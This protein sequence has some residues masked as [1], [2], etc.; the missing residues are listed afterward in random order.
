[1]T[2]NPH[3]HDGIFRAIF[4]EPEL[5]SG[6]L[7]A[8]LPQALVARIDWSTF[9]AA[10]PQHEEAVMTT[11]WDRLQEEG[12]I[13]GLAKGKAEAV[14]AVLAARGIAVSDDT[15]KQ[16]LACRDM[17]QLDRWLSRSVTATSAPEAIAD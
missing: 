17:T 7:R 5:I 14:L 12:E 16:V 11:M 9:Q 3:P 13:K 1:M 10:G 8:V 6:E 4:A 2:D 15:R